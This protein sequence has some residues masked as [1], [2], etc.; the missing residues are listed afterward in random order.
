MSVLMI[1][2]LSLKKQREK[3]LKRL[4]DTLKTNFNLIAAIHND[5]EVWMML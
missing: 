4:P 3:T 5:F 2:R 1:S